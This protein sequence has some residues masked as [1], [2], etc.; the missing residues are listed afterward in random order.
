M[1][2]STRSFFV[3][4]T[5]PRSTPSRLAYVH[6]LARLRH[7]RLV[8]RD[9]E[10]HHIDAPRPSHHVPHETL[11]TRHVYDPDEDIV[12]EAVVSEAQHSMVMPRSFSSLSLSQSMPVS[13]FMR[14]VFPWSMWPGRPM[15]IVFIVK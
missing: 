12:A 13:A 7:D 1:S 15:T 4:A 5:M 11:M 2:A 9:D 8:G 10:E 14:A 3:I 6:V